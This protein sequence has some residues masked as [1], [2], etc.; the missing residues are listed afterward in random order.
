[1]RFSLLVPLALSTALTVPLANAADWQA[2]PDKAPVPADNPMTPAKVKLG[3][4]LYFDPRLSSTGTVSCFSCH[5]VLEGGD[6]HRP[7]SMGVHG[8]KGGRNAPTVWDA[9]FQSVQFWDGRADTLEDQAKGPIANPVEMGM[10]DVGLAVDRIRKITGYKPYFDRAFGKGDNITIDNVAKAI[11]TY[12]RTLITPGSAYDRFVK[13]DKSALTAT[14]QRG[15]QA[16]DKAGCTAC[17]SGAMFSGP[18]M[19][20]GTGFYMKFPVYA[21]NP[22]VAKY[23]LTDDLGRYNV[24]KKDEDKNVW[25]VPTL[26]NL[27]FTAPY[28]H[29]GSVKSLDEAVRVMA[30]TQLNKT[31]PEQDV[32]DIV[33]FLT[34]LTGPFPSDTFPR[35]PPTP[36]DLLSED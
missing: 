32:R 33:A 13:G 30:A 35:L 9:A 28:M 15:M 14:Q 18:A 4:M 36:G 3:K 34:S 6:D 19:P 23:H 27:V 21:D 22:Y 8:L 24:T 5:S 16:F 31:L 26:R 11:A 1:M 17:H 10:A 29:N 20:V 2:L 7:V 25:R 12:E